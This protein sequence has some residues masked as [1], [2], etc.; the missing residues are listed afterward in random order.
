M[1]GEGINIPI[2]K[3]MTVIQEFSVPKKTKGMLRVLCV[4]GET[5][6]GTARE[7]YLLTYY[8][9]VIRPRSK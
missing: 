7:K 8:Y 2:P 4:G 1:D 5:K 3:M 6:L 9:L